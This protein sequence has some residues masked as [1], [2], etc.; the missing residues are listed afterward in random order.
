MTEDTRAQWLELKAAVRRAN[1]SFRK[2]DKALAT[3]SV[4][5]PYMV[6]IWEQLERAMYRAD[7]ELYAYETAH[8]QVKEHTHA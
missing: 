7:A 4:R 2:T 3:Y 8:P 6:Q 1:Y 5:P